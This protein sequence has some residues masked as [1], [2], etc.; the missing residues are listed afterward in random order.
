M[1]G[2]II[3]WSSFNGSPHSA[4]A[5]GKMKELLATCSSMYMSNSSIMGGGISMMLS[6][7]KGY[8]DWEKWL[9]GK[10]ERTDFIQVV[11][12]S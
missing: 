6:S 4:V 11:I 2:H 8:C 1:F 7:G 10:G 9:E 12:S 3:Y 5:I